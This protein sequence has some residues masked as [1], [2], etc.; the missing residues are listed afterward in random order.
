MSRDGLCIITTPNLNSFGHK[1]HKSSWNGIREDH[2]S[3]M[4]LSDLRRAMEDTGFEVVYAGSTFFSG[5][6]G[7]SD[8]AISIN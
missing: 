2:V 8:P 5:V 1:I 3:L 7:I 6:K 4:D